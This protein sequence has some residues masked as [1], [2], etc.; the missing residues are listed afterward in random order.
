MKSV[1]RFWKFL[2]CSLEGIWFE[3]LILGVNEWSVQDRINNI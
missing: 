1:A 2:I 3:N